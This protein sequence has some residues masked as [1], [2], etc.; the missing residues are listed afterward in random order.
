MLVENGGVP[1][2][3]AIVATKILSQLSDTTHNKSIEILNTL[4]AVEVQA[5]NYGN[6]ER[7]DM[8][9]REEFFSKYWLTNKPIIIKNFTN[10]WAANAKWTF[11]YFEKMFGD[12]M[13]QIQT[14]RNS[15]ANYE[16]NS[17][18]HRTAILMKDFIKQVLSE[19]TNDVY[20]TANNRLMQTLCGIVTDIEPLPPLLN[21]PTNT[22]HLYLW[23]GPKGAITP[24]HHDT[25]ALFH[26][27]IVGRKQWKLVSPLC[28]PKMYN[29][30]HVFSNVNLW[31]VDV[32]AH[33]KMKDVPIIDVVI[34]PGEAL[35]LPLGWWH[36]VKSLDAGISVSMTDLIFPNNWVKS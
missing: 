9:T 7:I 5:P 15:D 27:Q 20:A 10:G 6:I 28:T 24:T 13:I 21:Y 4:H 23:M 29:T 18:A 17:V 31:D 19:E 36:A 16:A 30:E 2:D 1:E 25:L 32:T 34:E 26:A 8:P 3:L 35:F 22:G 33:P 11:E 12:C 14:K